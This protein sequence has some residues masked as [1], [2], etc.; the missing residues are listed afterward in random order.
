VPLAN[1]RATRA[2]RVGPL[3]EKATCG[4]QRVPSRAPARGGWRTASIAGAVNQQTATTREIG[5]VSEV[6]SEGASDISGRVSSVH[7][8][9]PEVAYTGAQRDAARSDEFARIEKAL[10]ETVEGFRVGAVDVSI[11]T[12]EEAVVDQAQRN[13]EGTRTVGNVTTI[14]DYVVGSGLHEFECTGAWL[15]GSGYATDVGGDAYSSVAG[16][17]V[18]LRFRGRQLR[19]YG[20]A[21]KQQGMAEVHIDNQEPVL[22]DFYAPR[23]SAHTLLWTSPEL[24]PGEHTFWLKVS[25]RK[26][27]ES[28]YFWASVAKVEVVH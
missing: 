25:P 23:R 27:P 6:A 5:R 22:I 13:V 28:R 17:Q 12:G 2:T 26:N 10:R 19:F 18:K 9:A 24:S 16:D 20:S 7:D 4:Y 14:L 21:D 8:R 3:R 15:H 1:Y 11:D